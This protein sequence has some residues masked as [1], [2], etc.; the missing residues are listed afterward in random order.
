MLRGGAPD[1]KDGDDY[2]DGYHDTG[3]DRRNL[4][5]SIH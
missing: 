2:N 5:I 1:E 4:S 3:Y